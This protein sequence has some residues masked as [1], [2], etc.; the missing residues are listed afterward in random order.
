MPVTIPEDHPVWSILTGELV[1]DLLRELPDSDTSPALRRLHDIIAQHPSHAAVPLTP[2]TTPCHNHLHNYNAQH[3]FHITF[4]LTPESTPSLTT[5]SRH[6]HGNA[7]QPPSLFVA[8]YTPDYTPSPPPPPRKPCIRNSTSVELKVVPEQKRK[9]SGDGGMEEGRKS[10][11]GRIW[12]EDGEP[13]R[14]PT[15]ASALVSRMSSV[16]SCDGLRKL[17]KLVQALVARNTSSDVLSVDDYSFEATLKLC[18]VNVTDRAVR[19]FYNMIAYI[20][21]AFHMDR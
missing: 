9:I 6:L 11:K 1:V 7:A 20:R 2:Q 5:S 15:K 10:K 14:P 12:L 18:D 17:V 16:S 21:L 8:S 3:P 13:P 4:P 19:D